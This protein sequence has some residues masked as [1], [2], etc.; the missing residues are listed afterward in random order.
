MPNLDP[1]TPHLA[2]AQQVMLALTGDADQRLAPASQPHL[3]HSAEAVETIRKVIR[4]I[5]K[6]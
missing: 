5:A 6:E 3:C 4:R 2:P 1:N